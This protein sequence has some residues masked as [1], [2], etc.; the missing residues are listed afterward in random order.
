MI[1]GFGYID[2]TGYLDRLY[3]HLDYQ[4]KEIATAICNRLESAVSENIVA[5]VS[6][7][8][9]PFFE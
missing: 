5:H 1:V 9:R 3:V 8:A 4:R 6:I 2:K 7:T